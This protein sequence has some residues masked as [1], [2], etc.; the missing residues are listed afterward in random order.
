LEAA[1]DALLVTSHKGARMA[2][3]FFHVPEQRMLLVKEGDMLDLG[4]ITLSFLEAPM[5]PRPETMFTYLREEGVLFSCDLFSAHTSVGICDEDVDDIRH[6]AKRYF[7][8]VMMPFR[9]QAK[10]ALERLSGM[11]LAVIAPGHGPVYKNP[12]KALDGYRAWTS[13]ITEEK[14][15][16][17]FVSMDSSV[18]SMA[19]ALAEELMGEGIDVKLHNLALADPGEIAADM[20]D[21]SALVLGSPTYHGG[22]HPL[23]LGFMNMVASLR[24]PAMCAAFFGS[25]GWSG[26]ARKNAAELFARAG[27]RMEGGIEILGPPQENDMLALAGLA[28]TIAGKIKGTNEG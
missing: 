16:I 11:K 4:G 26:G 14:S 8:Q 17:A 9:A 7:G 3:I 22:L 6:L 25:H 1:P 12:Q 19:G 28:R 13:G 21:S 20:V 2:G 24:P 10:N 18:A 5:L 27:I 23:A 15:L